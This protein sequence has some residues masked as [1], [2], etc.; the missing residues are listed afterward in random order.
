MRTVKPEA[1]LLGVDDAPFEFEDD[2]TE[3]VGTVFRG[4]TYIEGVVMGEVTVDGLDAADTIVSM[5][6]ESRHEHQVQAALL[7][8]ITVAGFNVVD[9][10]HVAAEAGI[11]VVAVSRNEPDAERIDSGLEN[12]GRV[13]ER[14]ELIAAAGDAKT[15][16]TD[17]GTVYF[18]HAGVD[19]QTAR[20]ILDVATVRGQLPE[21]VR[22]SHMIAGA[23]ATGE[24]T[25]SA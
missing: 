13:E 5:V 19:E 1:R 23:V 18:Q 12:V 25:G 17:A 7:D 15:R 6:R 2:T 24:S 10:E 3:L 14:K 9:L 8:G 4:G 11:G 20:D 22:V 21:P 16:E